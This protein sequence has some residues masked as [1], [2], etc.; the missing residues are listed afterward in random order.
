M[1]RIYPLFS[2]SKGNASFLGTPDGGIL[3]DIGVSL[4]RL[5]A[6][7]ERCSL[8]MEAVKAVFLTHGHSDHVKGLLQFS[9]RYAV[10][11]YG[12]EKTMAELQNA[13]AVDPSACLCPMTAPVSTAGMQIFAFDTPHDTVQSCG[14]RIELPDGRRCAVCTDLGT[15]TETVQANLEGCDLVLLE[16]NYDEQLLLQGAY[17]HSIKMRIHSDHGHLSN[18]ACAEQALRLVRSGTKRLILGHI[19][20]EN[21]TPALAER[22]VRAALQEYQSGV[23]YLLQTA[24]VETT[25]EM[26]V[27]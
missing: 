27:F 1:A 24:P 26:V 23:D 7:M 12:Q 22:T 25:G 17:P 4:R 20:P 16:A 15:V 8:P 13:G 11:I 9:R 3:I 19:S 5:C 6:A 18:T 2:S 21:N 10:P 14:Y